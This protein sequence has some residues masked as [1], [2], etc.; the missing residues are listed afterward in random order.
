MAQKFQTVSAEAR[1]L[2][3][4]CRSEDRLIVFPLP[5]RYAVVNIGT[6]KEGRIIIRTDRGDLDY[7][8]DYFLKH[9]QDIFPF[10]AD[11]LRFFNLTSGGI[12]IAS[13]FL[14]DLKE[15]LHGAPFFSALVQALSDY[16][17]K[18]V[19]VRQVAE[20]IYKEKGG[21]LASLAEISAGERG[22]VLTNTGEKI[23]EF[24][25][26]FLTK[27]MVIPN[28]YKFCILP[29]NVD[30]LFVKVRIG[31][32]DEM[33]NILDK[34]K[35]SLPE[36]AKNFFGKSIP[37]GSYLMTDEPKFWQYFIKKKPSSEDKP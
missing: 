25:P 15:P 28:L 11:V 26:G 33:K 5:T 18:K 6:G 9:Q 10:C 23:S 7:D 36:E 35:N 1:Q 13:Y 12:C 22:Y 20:N 17:D 30:E 31:D 29:A 8:A 3:A 37:I 24:I 2:A 4:L 19:T 14:L 32:W 21:F 34:A 16:T 27:W